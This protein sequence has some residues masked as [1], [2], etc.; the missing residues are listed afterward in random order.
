MTWPEICALRDRRDD[1]L[2][3]AWAVFL[4]P[5]RA[6]WRCIEIETEVR[7]SAPARSSRQ[8]SRMPLGWAVAKALGL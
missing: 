3:D 4:D 6:R 5:A 8:R 2:P 7:S 1:L